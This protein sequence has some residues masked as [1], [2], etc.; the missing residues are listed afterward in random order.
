M[1]DLSQYFRTM[2][3]VEPPEEEGS[4]VGDLALAIP[5]GFAHSAQSLASLAGLSDDEEPWLGTSSYMGIRVLEGAVQYAPI[6]GGAFSALKGVTTVGKAAFGAGVAADFL[7]QRGQ[8]GRAVDLLALAIPELKDTYLATKEDELDSLEGR[9]KNVLDGLGFSFIAGGLAAGLRQARGRAK[10]G[11]A[12]KVD[13]A[14][15]EIAGKV[16]TDETVN[17]EVSLGLD[18][19]SPTSG[20]QRISGEV[21]T[22]AQRILD[23]DE[24]PLLGQRELFGFAQDLSAQVGRV[25]VDQPLGGKKTGAPTKKASVLRQE[26]VQVSAELLDA[27]A[28]L[29]RTGTL[30][31]TFLRKFWTF[32]EAQMS[33][34]AKKVLSE[35]WRLERDSIAAF[36]PG[37][38][39]RIGT[40]K[41]LAGE[42]RFRSPADWAIH[43]IIQDARPNN[44][45]NLELDRAYA[46]AEVAWRRVLDAHINQYGTERVSAALISLRRGSEEW[47]YLRNDSRS[48]PLELRREELVRSRARQVKKFEERV[49]ANLD[50][51]IKDMETKGIDPRRPDY[52][53]R[54]VDTSLR[55]I[56]LQMVD[57]GLMDAAVLIRSAAKAY[58]YWFE[59]NPGRKIVPDRE[60]VRTVAARVATLVGQDD[61]GVSAILTRMRG[62][63]LASQAQLQDITIELTAAST[64]L[65]RLGSQLFRDMYQARPLFKEAK[66]NEQAIQDIFHRYRL[67]LNA[68]GA[69][70]GTRATLGRGLRA[71]GLKVH[72]KS[73]EKTIKE[74]NA[75]GGVVQNSPAA[76]AAFF[77]SFVKKHEGL[78]KAMGL[79]A[80]AGGP[81]ASPLG[82]GGGS[83]G[84]GA[85][86]SGSFG[87]GQAAP[88]R[89]TADEAAAGLDML[90]PGDVDPKLI[91][92]ALGGLARTTTDSF[93]KLV[94]GLMIEG[95]MGHIMWGMRTLVGTIPVFS[96]ASASLKMLEVAAGSGVTRFFNT[97][98]TAVDRRSA[99][100]AAARFFFSPDNWTRG[101]KAFKTALLENQNTFR[102]K[103]LTAAT[104]HKHYINKE[105][106]DR[107]RLTMGHT[108]T[109]YQSTRWYKVGGAILNGYGAFARFPGRWSQAVD[110][111]LATKIGYAM[112]ESRLAQE[113]IAKGMVDE[114]IPEYVAKHIDLIIENG[115]LMTDAALEEYAGQIAAEKGLSGA[116]RAR[117]TAEFVVEAKDRLNQ[118]SPGVGA[119]AAN[120]NKVSDEG[121]F[122]RPLNPEGLSAALQKAAARSPLLRLVVPFIGMPTNALLS[123]IDRSPAALAAGGLRVFAE[124]PLGKRVWPSLSESLKNSYN[125]LLADSYSKDPQ[126]AMDVAGRLM[127]SSAI[128]GTFLMMSA[129]GRI[130]GTGSRDRKERE[131]IASLGGPPPQSVLIGDTWVSYAK[132]DPIASVLSA[133]ADAYKFVEDNPNEDD[134]PGLALITGIFIGFANNFVNK[135]YM[136]GIENAAEALNNAETYGA[137]YV[138]GLLKTIIPNLVSQAASADDPFMRD[139]RGLHET[140]LSALPWTRQDLAV[141]RNFLGEPIQ[142]AKLIRSKVAEQDPG[143]LA[144]IANLVS[145][146]MA[147]VTGDDALNEEILALNYAF[148]PPSTKINRV[149]DL[150][151][152]VA[153]N[154]RSLY[155]IYGERTST[156]TLGGRTVRQ[157]LRDLIGTA[158]YQRAVDVSTEDVRSPRID[159]INQVVERYRAAA[160]KDLIRS[161]PELKRMLAEQT[162]QRRLALRGQ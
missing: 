100:Q 108:D 150:R 158:K 154:G 22:H 36:E 110:S 135:S 90:P 29:L 58:R 32:M 31:R 53:Q 122:T 121:L 24:V 13:R 131:M 85:A 44:P 96:F 139:V 160:K 56:N 114:Q 144:R 69:V 55:D 33:E 162:R 67:Y 66:K 63:Q 62:D 1:A 47:D 19:Y 48:V 71:L 101:W 109:D 123:S 5:R 75:L 117:Y 73:L 126:A 8:D 76:A 45:G 68:L 54:V 153:A 157:A 97:Y 28:D 94:G 99:Q 129:E 46:E 11:D 27:H 74:F 51:T 18:E 59:K 140:M 57:E 4:L 84:P 142:S 64:V 65:F 136:Q 77:E 26:G 20:V 93:G 42:Y 98:T 89:M 141:R 112:A 113:A 21:E 14:I 61:G 40:D 111:A 133:I 106:I 72:D 159:M 104:E 161:Y 105:F 7:A 143:L 116:E 49:F 145:P 102:P 17:L 2:G 43:K 92:A 152:I 137:K 37:I 95:F 15:D 80:D 138:N 156:I 3:P 9:F 118:I 70:K 34:D 87:F 146:V 83:G 107:L 134:V 79:R 120:I 86:P 30:N 127:T 125:R 155:D 52:L 147:Q 128:L 81:A 148:T 91:E 103:A 12:R 88:A 124:S 119:L 25:L 149:I 6:F 82:P 23:Q 132:F 115:R 50:A 16:A 151:E 38:E 10:A 35:Q 60:M 130:T 41:E 78:A 39:A